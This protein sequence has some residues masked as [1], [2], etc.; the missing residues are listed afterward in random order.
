MTQTNT[1]MTLQSAQTHMRREI[2]ETP[3]AVARL[4]KNSGAQITEAAKALREK[5]PLFAVTVAR[6]SSDH[7]ALF[8][9]YAIEL[10]LHI[11][12]ASLG[13]SLASVYGAPL[14]VENGGAFCISQSG[15]SPDIVAMAETA[16]AGGALSIAL[17]NTTPAP[18]ADACAHAINI[19]A[20]PEKSVA[21]TKT[22]ICSIAAGLAILA[23]WTQDTA[24]KQAVAALPDHLRRAGALDWSPLSGPLSNAKSIYVLGRGPISAI[25]HESALKFKETCGIHAEAYS[26]AEVLH[27]PVEIVGSDF[28]VL[29]FAARD[30]AED[31]I[32]GIADDLAK[33]GADVFVTS[34]KARH[35]HQLP[36]C[37]TG[38][39][40]TDAL[41][42]VMAFYGFVEALSRARGRNPDEPQHLQKVTQTL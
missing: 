8:L 10:T 17:C 35:A 23:E 25:A 37:A 30:A 34:D 11:P 18:L 40:L 9:K 19:Q 39:P 7:A 15:K 22:Y 42:P 38:H 20:G 41:M 33:R 32:V 36:F 5:S 24:L 21:A 1:D 6:G 13:P 28:P 27:G 4:L 2:D 14:H 3:E 16:L 29:A 31:A 12:V 26:T